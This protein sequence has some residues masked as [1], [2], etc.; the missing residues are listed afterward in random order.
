MKTKVIEVMDPLL[1]LQKTGPK[2]KHLFMT[3]SKDN[4]GWKR[5]LAFNPVETYQCFQGDELLLSSFIE[6]HRNNF[7]AGYLAYDLGYELQQI[8]TVHQSNSNLPLVN[9]SAFLNFIEF[10]LQ[11]TTLHYQNPDFPDLIMEIIGREGESFQPVTTEKFQA[12]LNFETYKADFDRIQEEIRSGEYYQINYAHPMTA[13]SS[14]SGKEL[15]HHY[16]NK[17][18]ANYA[19]FFETDRANIISLSPESFIHIKDRQIRT[20]PIKGTRP[21]GQT[22]KEDNELKEELLASK[23]EEAELF[24]IIDLLRN[25]LGKICTTGSVNIRVQKE[26]QAL[27]NVFHTFAE[28]E[29]EL[30]PEI[31]NIEALLSMFPGGSITGCPKKRALQAIDNLECFRRGIYTGSIGFL[32]PGDEMEFNIAIRTLIQ[33][34]KQLFLGIGG[35]ITLL[36]EAVMEFTET[37][38]KAKSFLQDD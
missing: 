36:S 18:P 14:N 21:R 26:I 13:C 12:S 30:K 32:L 38:D 20:R 15:F 33:Q 23:K 3:W 17:N 6:Q 29:G 1:F 11:E 4:Q 19:A 27:A 37:F 10:G 34:G 35:G 2:E 31:N 7:L 28:I 9:F 8:K 16:L 24:M 5:I 22:L 25:D